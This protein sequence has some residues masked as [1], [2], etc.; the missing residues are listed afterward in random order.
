MAIS[1]KC[2][3]CGAVYP[4]GWEHNCTLVPKRA[5]PA[6]ERRS[7]VVEQGVE[8]VDGEPCPT[9]KRPWRRSLTN[10]ERQRRYRAR[11]NE[12]AL[13]PVSG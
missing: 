7:P 6:P 1:A 11:R 2:T 9:C 10:A 3:T 13:H 4:A 8:L 5:T 12:E